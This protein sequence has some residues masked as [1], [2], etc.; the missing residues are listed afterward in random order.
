[1]A[2]SEEKTMTLETLSIQ[3]PAKLYTMLT[4]RA[5]K[6]E[7][8]PA[9]FVESLLT[10]LI[11]PPHPYVEVVESR[12]GPHPVVKGTRI[13][14]NV[15]IGYIRAGYSPDDLVNDFFPHLTL[16]QIYDVL[17]YYEDHRAVIDAALETH[18]QEAW[19]QRLTE[20]LGKAAAAQLFG[21]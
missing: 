15:I 1:M 6:R 8:T 14:V 3:L 18:T 16:A 19:R 12:S 21:N 9:R 7:Q 20:R 4:E 11:L 2:Y 5:A 13:G 17:S 10:E